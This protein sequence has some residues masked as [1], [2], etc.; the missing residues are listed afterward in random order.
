MSEM[1]EMTESEA[2]EFAYGLLWHMGVDR[3]LPDGRKASDARMALGNA[4]GPA[5]KGI[6]IQRAKEWLAKFPARSVR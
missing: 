4:I 2:A 1:V 3:R 5:R 6:G